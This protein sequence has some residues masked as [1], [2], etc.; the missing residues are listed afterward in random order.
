MSLKLLWLP[1]TPLYRLRAFAGQNT[2]RR[3]FAG[4]LALDPDDARELNALLEAGGD[5]LPLIG[6]E[7]V[8]WVE[9]DTLRR[10][11]GG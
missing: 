1:G 9:P 8:G 4:E 11:A 2:Q 6:V 5:E 10:V 3:G 7:V